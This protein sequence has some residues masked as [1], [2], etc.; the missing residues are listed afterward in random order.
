M[1]NVFLLSVILVASA[2]FSSVAA[3]P[4]GVVPAGAGDKNLG[5]DGVKTRSIEM[6]RIKRE[7]AKGVI[8]GSNT[9]P[10]TALKFKEI[11]E[12]FEN[13]QMS[14]NGIINAY[15]RS[16]L[17]DYAK[18]SNLAGEMNKSGIRL[19]GNLFPVIVEKQDG[20]KSKNK[21]K[22][23]TQPAQTN[24]SEP[25]LPTDVK[26]LIVVIDNTLASFVGN[27]MFTNPTVVKADDNSKAK[28]DLD[29]LLMLSEALNQEA[30][31]MSKSGK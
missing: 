1:K 15:T 4:P 9:D 11:K 28:A 5:D 7:S 13:L 17:I 25:A 8:N 26:T 10:A 22:N 19:K 29:K 31:K 14:Q 24:Q 20:K 27:P 6:E 16:K 2:I 18:I 12:D 21:K 3:Q 23:D 30:D